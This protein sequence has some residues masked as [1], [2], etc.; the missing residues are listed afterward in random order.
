MSDED[1]MDA[2]VVLK[3]IVSKGFSAVTFFFYI[4][5][6]NAKLLATKWDAIIVLGNRLAYLFLYISIKAF[7][8]FTSL[9]C[10]CLASFALT[11]SFH[12]Q[13][14]YT[15]HKRLDVKSPYSRHLRTR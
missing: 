3:L 9:P 15:F 12:Q 4:S 7:S 1:M 6:A 8:M 11:L 2:D 13:Q 5:A 14:V 10:H